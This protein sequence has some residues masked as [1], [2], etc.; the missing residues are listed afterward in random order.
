M[1]VAVLPPIQDNIPMERPVRYDG[2]LYDL[3][4]RMQIEYFNV[5]HE[6]VLMEVLW[7]PL[8]RQAVFSDGFRRY[9]IVYTQPGEQMTLRK[10]LKHYHVTLTQ[11][12]VDGVRLMNPRGYHL[13]LDAPLENMADVYQLD[14]WAYGGHTDINMQG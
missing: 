13:V 11:V 1:T 5:N 9:T 7:D 4:Q 6:A 14:I 2:D 12:A 8:L 10:L 3:E